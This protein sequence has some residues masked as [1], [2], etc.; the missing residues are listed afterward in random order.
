MHVFSR[1]AVCVVK[2]QAIRHRVESF[3]HRSFNP[4]SGWNERS[5]DGWGSRRHSGRVIFAD[6]WVG[7]PKIFR[8]NSDSPPK[9]DSKESEIRSFL[10]KQV[11]K[12]SIAKILGVSRT[13]LQHFIN[14]R[15]LT[16]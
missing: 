5:E 3:A 14:S 11:S 12:A 13:T 9:L 10:S 2:I 16:G 15:N 1:S 8:K 7:H 6:F 4:L